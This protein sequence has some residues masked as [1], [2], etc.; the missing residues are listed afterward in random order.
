MKMLKIRNV[1]LEKG[2]PKICVSLLG[3]NKEE[4]QK[5]LKIIKNSP[6]TIVEWRVDKFKDVL[7]RIKVLF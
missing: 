1:A 3:D 2:I 7:D 4:I 5:E 6:A